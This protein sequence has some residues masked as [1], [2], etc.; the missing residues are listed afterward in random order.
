MKPLFIFITHVFIVLTTTAQHALENA[1]N[2]FVKDAIF[3][4]ASVSISVTDVLTGEKITEHQANTSIAPAS[5]VKLFATASALE[6][7]G[8]NHSPTTRIYATRPMDASGK[9]TGDLWIRGGGDISLGSKYFNNANTEADFL[10]KWADTLFKLGLRK[11]EGSVIGD[12]SEF[13]Y[14]GA[15]DGWNWSDM[16]NYYGAGPS[17]L[18]LFD[19]MLRYYFKV[20]GKVGE[21]ATLIQT[22]PAIDG[23][24]FNSY[25]LGSKQPGDN[26]Y[27]LGAPY[28]LDRFGTGYL[29]I[30]SASFMVKGSL[31]DPEL[32]F[33][34]ELHRA[35]ID[36]GIAIDEQPKGVRTLNLGVAWK[37]Y[38]DGFALL[39]TNTGKTVNDLVYWTNQKSVNIFAEQLIGLIGYKSNGNGD[40]ENG[41]RYVEKY[42][43]D[44]INTTGLYLTDGSGLSRNNAVSAS[45]FC[46]LLN[47]MHTSTNAENFKKSLAV[48]GVSGT[49]SEVCKN[50][51]AHGKIQAK[52]GTMKRI[53][54]YSGYANHP[55]GKTYSFAIIVNNYNTSNA[56]LMIRIEKFMNALVS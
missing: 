17:G 34:Q 52:S 2:T 38:T 4:N 53:K 12:G 27:I 15:P 21:K 10:K 56:Q 36:R 26:S 50:Q 6:I 32:Q 1:K 11:I 39:Y 8:A 42:W 28:S 35:L 55:N 37:R 46:A 19:N 18:P 31:P 9:I 54:S 45:H 48:A 51:A 20:T 41:L 5:T 22:I 25:I 16:G 7:L 43:K 24:Q 47:Y 23:L 14:Q 33:A 40:T 29:P 44:K 13:G 30:N 49:L 3:T